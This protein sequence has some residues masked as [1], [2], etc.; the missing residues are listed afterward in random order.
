MQCGKTCLMT[1]TKLNT[2]KNHNTVVEPTSLPGKLPNQV[3]YLLIIGMRSLTAQSRRNK[4]D[5]QIFEA[6][7]REIRK[8]PV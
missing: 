1:I 3:G 8:S 2:K 4:I 5:D 6:V 7:Y